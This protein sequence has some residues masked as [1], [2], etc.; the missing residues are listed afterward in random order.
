MRCFAPIKSISGAA[1][2]CYKIPLI[3][4]SMQRTR[5]SPAPQDTG[6]TPMPGR[7]RPSGTQLRLFIAARA[8]YVGTWMQTTRASLAGPP[9]TNS[10][11]LLGTISV[12]QWVP[13][14]LLIII[15]G[16]FADRFSNA[17]Y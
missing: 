1:V 4:V 10:P 9:L 11:F 14:T 15:G 16:A 2:W 13:V 3:V 8:L 5:Q 17:A 7:S 6:L 12:L